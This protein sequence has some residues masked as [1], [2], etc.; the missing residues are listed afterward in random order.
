MWG[1]DGGLIQAINMGLTS[2]EVVETSVR[3]ILNQ[4]FLAGRFDPIESV[5][6]NSIGPDAVNSIEHQAINY[7]TTLQT[8]VLLKNSKGALPLT[9]GRKI[10][11]VGP[12]AVTRRELLEDYFGDRVCYSSGDTIFD[13]VQ[14]I[15]EA[16]A[17]ANVGGST[18]VAAGVDISS[19]NSTGIAAAMATVHAADVVVLALGIDTVNVE[20]EGLDR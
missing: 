10:A 18:T 6:W 16:V 20:H 3:R 13:C 2:E 1:F 14:S 12:H 17:K 5:E 7:E 11:V 4:H 19:T 8:L 9:K 15:G